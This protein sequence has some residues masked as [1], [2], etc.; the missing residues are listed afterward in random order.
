MQPN[1]EAVIMADGVMLCARPSSLKLHRGALC[2]TVYQ[3]FF[4]VYIDRAVC[5]LV[6]QDPWRM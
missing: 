6:L 1:Q 2:C 5:W 3:P 4:I